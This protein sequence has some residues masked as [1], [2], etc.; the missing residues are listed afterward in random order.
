MIK[1]KDYGKGVQ[2]VEWKTL[3][4]DTGLKKKKRKF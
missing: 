1:E 4:P 3:S 2:N